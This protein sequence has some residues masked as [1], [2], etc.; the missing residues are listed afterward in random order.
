ML[1]AIGHLG[2]SGDVSD[3]RWTWGLYCLCAHVCMPCGPRC[4]ISWALVT[5][6]EVWVPFA[7]GLIPNGAQHQAGE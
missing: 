6:L 3:F 5:T 1:I 7:N 2:H 4:V